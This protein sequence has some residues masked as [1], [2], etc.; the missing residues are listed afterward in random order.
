MLVWLWFIFG[1]RFCNVERV[2]DG[3][4]MCGRVVIGREMVVGVVEVR[5]CKVC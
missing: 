1:S 5:F 4:M 3:V 2:R